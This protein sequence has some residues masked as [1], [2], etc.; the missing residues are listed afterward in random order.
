MRF[1]F[2][3]LSA[4]SLASMGCSRFQKPDRVLY[5]ASDKATVGPLDYSITDA[6]V[7]Q[8]LGDDP[9]NLRTPR[10]RFYLVTLN[11]T[12]TG[13]AEQSIPTLTLV[14]DS[15]RN[16]TELSDGAGVPNWLGVVRKVGP[17][18]TARG[19]VLFDAPSK[20]YRLRLNDPLDEREIAIDVPLNFIHEQLQGVES[21]PAAQP[22]LTIPAG[23]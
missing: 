9:N 14:D 3:V 4:C 11:V 20:H 23:K 16:Y 10:E 21:T 17:A 6:E 1:A 7:A 5:A 12:N 8:Q 2:V 18:R 13:S 19:V 22:D 15:G